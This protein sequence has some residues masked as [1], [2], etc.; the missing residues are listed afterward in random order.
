M[1][2]M[3]K[4]FHVLAACSL[5]TGFFS[6][7][8]FIASPASAQETATAEDQAST[9]NAATDEAPGES[10]GEIDGEIEG[11][12][13]GV[14]DE[15]V[16]IGNQEVKL[17]DASVPFT[18]VSAEEIQQQAPRN[19]ADALTNIPSLQVENT[20]GNTNNEYRFRGVGA[21][22]TQF[23]ELEEDGIPIMRDGP[24][25]LYRVHNGIDRI[26]TVRGGNSPILRTAAIGA[27]IDFRY[28]EGSRDKHDG[29]VFL[30]VSDFGMR[31]VETWL[32]GPL[33]DRLTYSVS[34]YYTTDDGVR[35]VDYPANEGYNLHTSLKYH[36]EDESGYFKVSARAFDEGNIV[37]LA[38]PLLGDVDN[39]RPFPGGPD[40]TT[41]S[42]LSREIALANTF[43]APGVPSTLDLLDGNAS[44][45][46]YVG[47]EFSRD[48]IIGDSAVLGVVARNRLT[49]VDS[50]FSGYYAAGFALG[51]DF[52]TGASLI[53]NMLN[54]RTMGAGLVTYAY[55][56]P[57]GFNPISYSVT[58][59]QGSVLDF[60]SVQDVNG[61]GVID[62]GEALS[63]ATTLANGN[64]IFMP[65]AAFDQDN[66]FTSFQ[67]DIE[68]NLAW[69][70]GDLHHYA[71]VGYYYL[72]MERS[73]F[74]RQQLFLIDLQPQA[75]RVDVN[76]Q[77]AD[78][79]EVTLTDDGFLT[80]NH[81]LNQDEI[82]TEIDAFY[83]TYEL[84]WKDLTVDVGVR[85]DRF[86]DR[87]VFAQVVNVFGD[88]PNQT[89]LPEPGTTVSP[90]VTSI[91]RVNGSFLTDFDFTNTET[92]YTLGANY[93]FTE[94]VGA[95]GRFTKGHLPNRNGATETDIYELGLR[96]DAG[97][98]FVAA[99]LFSLTQEGDIQERGLVVDGEEVIVQF[100][101][102]RESVGLE[103]EGGW[104]ISKNL[105]LSFSGTV[106]DP[107]FASGGSATA[108]PGSSVSQAELDAAVGD[109]TRIDGNQIAN[110]PELLG[111]LML[112]YGFDI[113][114]Y[115]RLS[116]NI[117]A[118]HVGEVPLD[119]GNS[120]FIG[121]YTQLNA[122][123][124]FE[125]TNGDWYARL[126]VQNLT[127]EEAIQ[128]VFGGPQS[129]TDQL[130]AADGFYGRPLLG[131]NVVF[132]IGYR[133]D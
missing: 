65:V 74:N 69:S 114:R 13:E 90:A 100:R 92:S 37:Y 57:N 36:F 44:K 76:L 25:F 104:E 79:T 85:R 95:Y 61:N 28:K 12:I 110:Q 4:T 94:N 15:V 129:I 73:Q 133:F 78:G 59:Q 58:N 117:V 14:F 126:N 64:G 27:V 16:V 2:L 17:I 81:W 87:R 70:T 7:G 93:R 1:K 40:I 77:G 115:G 30:G 51:G 21:G 83:G 48:W 119:D 31:R 49:D 106:Q 3:I 80:H 107:E 8:S 63:A 47:T 11:E 26:D 102:D 67:Q 19:I 71:S 5:L 86:D 54:S 120:S 53:P 84:N 101:T 97:P 99:N 89:P 24:D 98:F 23:L 127:D 91:Q 108:R 52:Q 42:L 20:S 132:G 68:A 82:N 131:R 118:R 111:N 34:A 29:D 123:L 105:S 35:E 66:P 41:G 45:M 9:A 38:V 50:R 125:S 103:L 116:S 124:N 72:S 56:M 43:S 60:G 75:N 22:G 32:G 10:S 46:N 39:P 112:Q 6:T 33:T 55:A 121:S 18:T 122:G 88:G 62:P 96:Y 128:R 109:L 113:G 130:V